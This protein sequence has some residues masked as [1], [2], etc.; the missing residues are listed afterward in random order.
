MDTAAVAI[1]L[2]AVVAVFIVGGLLWA[3]LADRKR[4]EDVANDTER[5]FPDPTAP[6]AD[7]S[8]RH[9]G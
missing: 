6:P 2:G 9:G 4:N 3:F 7:P 5:M 8:D 1:F